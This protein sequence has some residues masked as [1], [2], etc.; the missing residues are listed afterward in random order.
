MPLTAAPSIELLRTDEAAAVLRCSIRTVWRMIERG[1]L[2]T[3]KVGQ[4]WRIPVEELNER[5]D[6]S[7]AAARS[8]A[9]NN[10]QEGP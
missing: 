8:T 3:V 9:P 5:L 6:P 1:E 2:R 4:Q 7:A 10:E